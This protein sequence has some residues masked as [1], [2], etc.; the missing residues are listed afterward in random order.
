V[1]A[2]SWAAPNG[3][4]VWFENPG[5]PKRAWRVHVLKANWARANQIIAADLDGD[6]RTDLV[7]GA[8]GVLSEVRW[9]RNEGKR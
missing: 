6:G 7:A 4:A 1:A 3:R 2:T 5:D 8:E 9:W